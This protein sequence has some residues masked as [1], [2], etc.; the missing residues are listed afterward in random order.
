[1]SVVWG[2]PNGGRRWKWGGFLEEVKERPG[3]WAMY[4]EPTHSNATKNI[5][6]AKYLRALVDLY[7]LR[8]S[9]FDVNGNRS[10]VPN[11][12]WFLYARYMGPS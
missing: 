9:C 3:E 4:P 10:P 11:R 7:D 12:Q 2:E 8:L 5:A 6:T 1:M